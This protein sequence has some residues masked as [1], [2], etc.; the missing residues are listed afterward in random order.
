MREPSRARAAGLRSVLTGAA[1]RALAGIRDMGEVLLARVTNVDGGDPIDHDGDAADVWVHYED[2]MTGQPG[3]ARLFVPGNILFALPRSGE[4]A[5]VV[6]PAD[7]LGP[8]LSYLLHGDIGDASR[9]PSWLREKVG[10]WIKDKVLRLESAEDN[11]E[12]Q[13][14]ADVTVNGGTLAVARRT[15]PVNAGTLTITASGGGGVLLQWTYTDA[16]GVST[17]G[18]GPSATISIPLNGGQITAGAPHFKA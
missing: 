3:I 18:P 5:T 8:G 1:I 2:A 16:S 13:S 7:G 6:R 17:P 14:G 12:I 4:T 9:L 10:L 11:V 15:D